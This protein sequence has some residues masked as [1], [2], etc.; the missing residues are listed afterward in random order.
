[1]AGLSEEKGEQSNQNQSKDVSEKDS[2]K[3]AGTQS[4]PNGGAR[5]WFQVLGSFLVFFN[6]WFVPLDTTYDEKC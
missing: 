2:S 4:P 5:A 1:M 3:T 6:I